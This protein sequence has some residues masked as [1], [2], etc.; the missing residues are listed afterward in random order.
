V[1]DHPCDQKTPSMEDKRDSFANETAIEGSF[2]SV[3]SEKSPRVADKFE[4]ID[5]E[6]Q[7]DTGIWVHHP[8]SEISQ[9]W[10][11]RKGKSRRTDTEIHGEPNDS[12]SSSNA[13]ASGSPKNDCSSTDE[14]PD[15]KRPMTS[16]QRGI[17]KIGSVFY[18]SPKKEDHTGSFV[19]VVQSPRINLRAVN[20]M[21]IGVKFVVDDN[22]SGPASGKNPKEENAS[23]DENCP[24]SPS[25]GNMKD[26]AK[27]FLKQAGKSA[28]GIKH[29]LS[30]KGSRTSRGEMPAGTQRE[31]IAE[32][33]SSDD[34]SSS[35]S[36]GVERIPVISKAISSGCGNDSL[37][38]EEHA[39][40][41]DE[42]G[43]DTECPI[44]NE[45]HEDLD[46]KY[47]KQGSP[48]GR[49]DVVEESL[50]PKLAGVDLE[51]EKKVA[52]WEDSQKIAS[53]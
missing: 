50:Q 14:N 9:I 17:R 47:D 26:M 30:R 40:Q 16:V 48:D 43:M 10:E 18:K 6:G 15:D 13:A 29:A 42:V 31:S 45:S 52:C 3:S 53:Q 28:R 25:K 39:V 24:E 35:C 46:R 36:P 37:N 27:S 44:E 32:S 19:G 23:L 7:K 12:I 22:P 38:S 8:G 21:E 49:G 2:S 1:D 51:A 5:I 41:T 20:A 11:P 33:D 34:E 4:P